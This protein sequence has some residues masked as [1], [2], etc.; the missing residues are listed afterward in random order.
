MKLK[1]VARKVTTVLAIVVILI[2]GIDYWKFSSAQNEIKGIVMSCGGKL[3]SILDWP[4][5]KDNLFVFENELSESQIN[6]LAT[7]KSLQY[8][9]HMMIILKYDLEESELKEIRE[10]LQ[11]PVSHHPTTEQK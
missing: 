1:P 3:R 8:R 11:L 6:E 10:R 7:L 2:I 4:I 9:N 5:G